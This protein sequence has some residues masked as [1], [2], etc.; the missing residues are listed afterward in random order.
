MAGN[1]HAGPTWEAADGSKVTG[2]QVAIA[3]ASLGN[4]ALQLVKTVPTMGARAMTCVS[5]SSA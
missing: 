4:I 5:T 2:E 3:P 1:C